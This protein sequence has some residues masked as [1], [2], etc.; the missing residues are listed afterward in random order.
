MDY[1][2]NLFGDM[3]V[4]NVY[5]ELGNLSPALTDFYPDYD[6]FSLNSTNLPDLGDVG[7]HSSTII[8]HHFHEQLFAPMTGNSFN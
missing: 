7:K 3:A 4:D 6:S 5:S 8:A 2:E 1:L